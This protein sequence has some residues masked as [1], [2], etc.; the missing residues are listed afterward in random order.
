MMAADAPTKLEGLLSLEGP[1][2][3]EQSKTGLSFL[4]MTHSPQSWSFH[5]MLLHVHTASPLAPPSQTK[6]KQAS[7]D[8]YSPQP[9]QPYP[10][11]SVSPHWTRAHSNSPPMFSQISQ[12]KSNDSI[13]IVQQPPSSSPLGHIWHSVSETILPAV[14]SIEEAE[15]GRHKGIIEIM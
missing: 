14:V 5:V 2:T 11:K 3:A 8:E 1:P 4:S 7:P 15:N 10:P 12:P 9:L 13:S 6:S